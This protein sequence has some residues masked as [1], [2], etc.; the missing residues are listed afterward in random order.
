[1][2]GFIDDKLD[3]VADRLKDKKVATDVNRIN[4]D[5]L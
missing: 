3:M 5:K 2:D 4:K 1:M